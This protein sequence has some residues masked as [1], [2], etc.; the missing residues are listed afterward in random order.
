MTYEPP[1]LPEDEDAVATGILGAMVD[2]MPGWVPVDGAPEVALA[3]EIAGETVATRSLFVRFAEWAIAGFGA[4][5]FNVQPVVA[6]AASIQ[7]EFTVTSAGSQIPAGFTVVGTNEDGAE[8]TFATLEL[9]TAETTTVTGTATAALLGTVGNDVPAGPLVVATASA[10]VTAAE[11]LAPSAGGL[12]DEPLADYLVRLS[13]QLATLSFGGILPRDLALLARS[14]PGVDRAVGVDLYDALSEQTNVPRTV[15]V[16][17]V[18]ED[19]NPVSAD[20]KAD[21]L[22]VLE[23]SREANLVIYVEDPTYTTVEIEYEAL[24]TPSADPAAVKS[25]VDAALADYLARWGSTTD[26]PDAWVI[27][28]T[29]RVFDVARV[30]GSVAGVLQLLDVKLNGVAADLELDGI[31]PLPAP[32]TAADDP[33]TIDGTVE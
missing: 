24:A 25:A 20:I 9:L 3:T 10:V 1:N 11:A 7:V 18:D 16:F 29:M 12:D 8:V 32:V 5:V 31:A 14:V 15:T 17:V 21:V 4:T 13:D 26:D 23:A 30:I 33:S 6:T 27:S 28:S 22:D 2:A 19:G